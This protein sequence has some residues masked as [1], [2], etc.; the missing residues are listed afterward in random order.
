MTGR[1]LPDK[2]GGVFLRR[3]P[4]GR[5]LCSGIQAKCLFNRSSKLPLD[6]F[7]TYPIII[8]KK[9]LKEVRYEKVSR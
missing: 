6:F 2:E 5:L 9:I 8:Y 7:K 1:E 4:R 3:K